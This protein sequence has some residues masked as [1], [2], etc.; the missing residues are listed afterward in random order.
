V[1]ANI[2]KSGFYRIV[3]KETGTY[4]DLHQNPGK[5]PHVVGCKHH[6]RLSQK[7]R[8]IK[9]PVSW[10]PKQRH[11]KQQRKKNHFLAEKAAEQQKEL[12]GSSSGYSGGGGYNGGYSGGGYSGGGVQPQPV[13]TNNLCGNP[14]CGIDHICAADYNR[15]VQPM[16]YSG[17]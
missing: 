14:T 7:W 6:H 11:D 2:K 15:Q 16:G 5:H 8:F 9:T 12:Q 10:T 17:V 13:R 3:N 4:L 1:V